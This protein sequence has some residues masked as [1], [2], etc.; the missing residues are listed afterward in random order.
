MD[1]FMRLGLP[2]KRQT[3]KKYKIKFSIVK[4]IK[5]KTIMTKSCTKNNWKKRN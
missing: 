2:C 3:Q 1:Q 4:K 5:I